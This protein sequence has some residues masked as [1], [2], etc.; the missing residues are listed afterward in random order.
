MSTHGKPPISQK[1]LITISL[2][3]KSSPRHKI[4]LSHT[5]I[6]I[7]LVVMGV[8]VNGSQ[9]SADGAVMTKSTWTLT[10]P[11]EVQAAEIVQQDLPGIDRSLCW[12]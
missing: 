1:K 7:L 10:E 8:V 3:T 9:L 11:L 5:N 2:A 6:T 4:T 12:M